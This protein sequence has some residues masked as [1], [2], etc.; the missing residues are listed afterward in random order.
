MK[1]AIG[2]DHGGLTLKEVIKPFLIEE[3][4]AVVDFGPNTTPVTIPSTGKRLA[5]QSALAIVTGVSQF[6][7]PVWVFRWRL[8]RCRVSGGLCVLMSLWPKCQESTMTPTSWYWV[9]GFWVRVWR[10]GLSK[11]GWKLNSPVIVTNDGSMGLAPSK[12]NIQN[13]KKTELLY[14]QV[15]KIVILYVK[16]FTEKDKY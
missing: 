9:P 10:Y 14:I 8:T 7:E 15:Y 13:S 16:D 12:K 2:S 4:H 6:A 3:G 11:S 5:K 1:I